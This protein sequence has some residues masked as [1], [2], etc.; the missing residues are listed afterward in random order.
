GRAAAALLA[1]M[2]VAASVTLPAAAQSATPAAGI[3]PL[4]VAPDPA[5]CTQHPIGRDALNDAI[6]GGAAATPAP[7][8]D[9]VVPDGPP[10]SP[11]QQAAV[12]GM[13]RRLV[14]CY[15]AGELLRAYALF[16][17]GY[18]QRVFGKQGA[19]T[20]AAYDSLA[21]PQP[22]DADERVK[23]L[24][25]EHIRVLPDG[26]IGATVILEYAVIPMPKRFLMVFVEQDGAWAID[27]ILGEISFSVP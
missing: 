12:Y 26:R 11:E 7:F 24:A 3:Y 19:Y 10:A 23:I 27:D 17:P 25:I 14:A 4:P 1:A 21:T 6:A 15:S 2:V 9:G 8:R 18:F 16:T 20:A 13:V 5:L 22:A